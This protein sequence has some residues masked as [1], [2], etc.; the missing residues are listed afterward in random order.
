MDTIANPKISVY[1]NYDNNSL[2]NL[3]LCNYHSSVKHKPFLLE[4]D[5]STSSDPICALILVLG[6]IFKMSVEKIFIQCLKRDIFFI[7]SFLDD[8]AS[9]GALENSSIK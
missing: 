8:R 6:H 9:F 1:D 4:Y 5:F 2:T 3:Y 7:K